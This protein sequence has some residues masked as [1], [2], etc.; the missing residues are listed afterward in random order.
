[1]AGVEIMSNPDLA[2][3]WYLELAK[4]S[5]AR[6]QFAGSD[7]FLIL[8]GAAACRSG[9]LEVA[10]IC[11]ERVLRHNPRHLLSRWP[12]FPD[13][14]RSED[15][16]TF[17]HQLERFCSLEKAESLLSGLGV[18]ITLDETV[19]AKDQALEQ[20]ADECWNEESP[21]IPGEPETK[22]NGKTE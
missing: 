9:L 16:A 3:I 20:L 1:M 15:F 19:F 13:A 21:P 10:E 6:R 5:Q 14:L 11:R 18:I 2:M 8:A 4:L 12:T 17:Q 22:A 7:R